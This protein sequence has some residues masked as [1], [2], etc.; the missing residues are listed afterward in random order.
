MSIMGRRLQLL[1]DQ[2]RYEDVAAEAE[3][4][5]RSVAAVIREAIDLRFEATRDERRAAAAADVV[6]LAAR[7]RARAEGLGESAADLT[8][9]T[10]KSSTGSSG[11]DAGDRLARSG[12]R[13]GAWLA[14]GAFRRRRL[15]LRPVRFAA[16]RTDDMRRNEHTTSGEMNIQVSRGGFP[17]AVAREP[18]RRERLLDNY[19]ADLINRDVVQLSEIE[20]GPPDAHADQVAG[21]TFY[22]GQETRS[23][24][25]RLRAV[26]ISAVW[27]L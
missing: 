8:R 1:L 9:P 13:P 22:T 27:E 24:G 11:G 25:D 5:G 21:R 16:D 26:P 7:A 10:L 14:E 3:R 6:R 18:A 12:L 15:L 2:A 4:S 19:V 20:R 23:F 17:E